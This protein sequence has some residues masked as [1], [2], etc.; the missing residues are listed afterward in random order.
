MSPAPRVLDDDEAVAC[1]AEALLS[2]A[3]AE[4][5]PDREL[6][7]ALAGGSTPARLYRRLAVASPGL[8]WRRTVLLFGDE[9]HV[10]PDHADSNYRMVRE[11]LLDR[12]A[13]PPRVLRV[14]GELA[15]P[16]Q[17]ARDY[18]RELARVFTGA[19]VPRLDVVLLGIGE[20]G[21]TASLFPGTAALDETRRWAV[22]NH[23]PQLDAWRVTLTLP[24]LCAARHVVFL[25]TGER[26]ARVLA[27][28]FGGRPHPVPHPCERVVPDAGR[29][30]ILADR[31]AASLL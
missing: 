31:P 12:L 18:E 20:D 10:A 28:A 16:H 24:V 4:A 13:D 7:I 26:K 11:S 25:V 3:A 1:A 5:G 30:T 23:V 29:R 2:E 22:A 27:E 8:P 14:R 15:D 17:A 9:R 21:H 19:R 6:S